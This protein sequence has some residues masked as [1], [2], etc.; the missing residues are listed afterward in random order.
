[1]ADLRLDYPQ[2]FN[3]WQQW[4][5]GAAVT[6]NIPQLP[7]PIET[8]ERYLVANR[9]IENQYYQIKAAEERLN[10]Y[11]IARATASK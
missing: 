7:T 6:Q 2:S 10:K 11:K 4:L 9:N 5:A 1:M 3:H 8:R